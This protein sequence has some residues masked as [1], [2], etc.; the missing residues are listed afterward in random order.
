MI[1]FNV[2]VEIGQ[3]LA[4]GLI[5]IAMR[6]WRSTSSFTRHAFTANFVLMACGLTLAGYQSTG[7][8]TQ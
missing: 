6:W 8:L 4:L 1:A 2:G 5:L 3:L 7:F